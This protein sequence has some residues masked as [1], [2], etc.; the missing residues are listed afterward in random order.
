MP[1]MLKL[2]LTCSH[3]RRNFQ[4]TSQRKHTLTTIGAAGE[5][6]AEEEVVGVGEV[7]GVWLAVTDRLTT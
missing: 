1:S 2:K 5:P 3:A 4:S 7:V 6:V